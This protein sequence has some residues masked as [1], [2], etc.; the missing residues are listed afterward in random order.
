MKAHLGGSVLDRLPEGPTCNS[1]ASIRSVK[2]C[3]GV[4]HFFMLLLIFPERCY[5]FDDVR[6]QMCVQTLTPDRTSIRSP[7]CFYTQLHKRA[8]TSSRKPS[9][10]TPLQSNCLAHSF[11]SFFLLYLLLI[12]ESTLPLV[13]SF[14]SIPPAFRFRTSGSHHPRP[15]APY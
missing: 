12:P 8:Q 7:D 15:L 6:C 10:S 4:E 5:L 1:E 14:H 2:E 3:E 11:S 13:Y 9:K